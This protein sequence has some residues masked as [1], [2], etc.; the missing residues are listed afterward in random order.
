VTFA[1]LLTEA[2]VQDLEDIVDYIR[3]NDG[4]RQADYVLNRIEE[5]LSTLVDLP[6]RGHFPKELSAL[7]IRQYREIFFKPYRI[8]YQIISKNIYI[9]LITDGRRDMQSI[10]ERRLLMAGS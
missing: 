3:E 6:D 8:I 7:G 5:T 4:S 2:A 1:I 10:L 9:M